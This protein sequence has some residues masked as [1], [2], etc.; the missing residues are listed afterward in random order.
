[1]TRLKVVARNSL[2]TRACD[3]ARNK[4]YQPDRVAKP[5]QISSG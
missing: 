3:D 5:V 4:E 2:M 1:M